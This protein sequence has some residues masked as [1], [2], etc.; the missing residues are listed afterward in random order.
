MY[1]L[2]TRNKWYL[3]ASKKQQ[4]RS[5]KGLNMHGLACLLGHSFFAKF[6]LCHDDPDYHRNA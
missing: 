4:G 5:E 6:M 3:L 2:D 1:H